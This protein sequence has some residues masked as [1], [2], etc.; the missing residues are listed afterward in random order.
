MSKDAVSTTT[1]GLCECC[2]HLKRV[3]LYI[4]QSGNSAWVCKEC[5]EGKKN[6]G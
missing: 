3:R 2:G 4:L 5:R 1:R 6:G